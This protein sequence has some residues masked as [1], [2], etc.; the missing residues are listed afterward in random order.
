MN[1][2][3]SMLH[4]AYKGSNLAITAVMGGEIQ[5][6]LAGLA[7]VLPHVKANRL[8]GLAVTSAKRTPFAPDIPS[9]A[10][11]GVP[12]Y[13]F[14][15]WYGLAFP[16]GTPRAIVHKTSSELRKLLASPDVARRFASAGIE[17]QTNTPEAFAAMIAQEIPKWQKVAKAANIRAE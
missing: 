1:A 15:V 3:L 9:V 12:N 17:P 11:S 8:K 2:G 4:V 5:V 10:E 16:G 7:T 13:V 14:D 6:A